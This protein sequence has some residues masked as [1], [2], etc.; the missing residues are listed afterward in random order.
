MNQHMQM[1]QQQNPDAAKQTA[2]I[3][4]QGPQGNLGIGNQEPR[5]FG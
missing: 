1:L 2:A 4:R 5:T 3:P